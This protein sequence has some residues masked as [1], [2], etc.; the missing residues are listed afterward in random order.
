MGEISEAAKAKAHQMCD[1]HHTANERRVARLIQDV[2]D[3]AKAADATADL[4]G[5]APRSVLRQ[6][7]APFILPEPVD[8]LL[9]EARSLVAGRHPGHDE[10]GYRCRIMAGKEDDHPAVQNTLAALKRGIEI[11]SAKP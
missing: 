5:F 2:S 4:N 1:G 7:F 11:G 6:H 3:A 9:I 8:P 10:T